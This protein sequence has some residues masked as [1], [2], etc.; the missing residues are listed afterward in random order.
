MIHETRLI[1]LDGAVHTGPAIRS[2]MGDARG[3]WEGDTLVIETSGFIGNKNGIGLNGGGQPHSADMRLTERWTRV[4]PDTM[5][6]EAVINDPKT[7]TKPWKVA[8]PIKEDKEYL[9][10]EYACHEGNY[11]MRDILSGARTEEAAAKK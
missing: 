7:W 2:Y 11:A 3:H 9:L 6:Y 8:F 5:H 10:G 1:P 4:A